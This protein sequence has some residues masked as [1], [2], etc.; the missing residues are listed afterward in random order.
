V[1]LFLFLVL[2][3]CPMVPRVDAAADPA[4]PDAVARARQVLAVAREALGG[5]VALA[6]L[7]A[8]SLEGQLRRSLTGEDGPTEMAGS[9]RVDVLPPDHYLRVDTLSPA[10]GL[11]GI[12][13]AT[14]LDGDETWSGPLPFAGAPNIIV[15]TAPPGDAA[16]QG[17]LRERVQ[18]EAALFLVSTLMAPGAADVTWL[19]EAE[20]PE[21]KAEILQVT[22]RGGLDARLFLDVKTH[23]P[24]MLTFRDTPPRMMMRRVAAPGGAHGTPG[25]DP[26]APPSPPAPSEATLFLSDWKR[27]GGVLLPHAFNKTLD[28]KPYEE[29]VV[30]RYVVND[31]KVTPDKFRKRG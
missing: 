11:P 5:E 9:I 30:S 15:R 17:R 7:H 12:P 18:R 28:G 14:G 19:G 10:P 27:V 20:A 23:R 6:A 21:G 2:G 16:A 3:P 25:A 24:L 4:A 31:P 8:L 13:L 1:S 29:L 22:G 26:V